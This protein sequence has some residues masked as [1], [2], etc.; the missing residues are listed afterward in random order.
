M[1]P[2]WSPLLL[3]GASEMWT[4]ISP[5]VEMK[6]IRKGWNQLQ[7]LNYGFCLQKSSGFDKWC[8]LFVVPF[9]N[10]LNLGLDESDNISAL[11]ARNPTRGSETVAINMCSCAAKDIMLKHAKTLVPPLLRESTSVA[12]EPYQAALLYTDTSAIEKCMLGEYK[13]RQSY[14]RKRKNHDH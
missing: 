2:I 9:D 14:V 3:R 1:Q 8:A 10:H 4:E 13:I 12:R 5:N 7:C 6:V 11:H